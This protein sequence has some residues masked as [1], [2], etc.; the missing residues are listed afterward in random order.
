MKYTKNDFIHFYLVKEGVLRCLPEL[1]GRLAQAGHL[2]KTSS[3]EQSQANLDQL[4]P[5]EKTIL[6]LLNTQYKEKFGFPFV[7]C[8]RL[9]KKESIIHGLKTRSHHPMDTE[10]Q[11]GIEEVMKICELRLKDIVKSKL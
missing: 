8:A 9:N 6:A 11:I 3:F 10:L 2:S 1:A 7:I 5:Q 4:S